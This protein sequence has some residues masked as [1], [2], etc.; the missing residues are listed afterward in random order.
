MHVSFRLPLAALAAVLL[1]GCLLGGDDSKARLRSY[2]NGLY[3]DREFGYS[4]SFPKDWRVSAYDPP[5]YGLIDL[6]AFKTTGKNAHPGAYATHDSLYDDDTL[7]EW[8]ESWYGTT[9]RDSSVV[10]A[11]DIR[12]G[13]ELIRVDAW[14]HDDYGTE[15]MRILCFKRKNSVVSIHLMHYAAYIDTSADIRALDSSLTFFEPVP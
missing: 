6:S 10:R 14:S 11:A 1:T 7:A 12:G 5:Y 4:L 3:T 15:R 2:A 8:V 13:V 9:Y